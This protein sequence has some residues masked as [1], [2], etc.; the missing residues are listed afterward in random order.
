M[1]YF[2][3]VDNDAAEDQDGRKDKHETHF[4]QTQCKKTTRKKKLGGILYYSRQ[5][6]KM[7]YCRS[8]QKRDEVKKDGWEGE[9]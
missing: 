1:E 2:A 3:A 9:R 8:R 4:C 6:I 7:K 5:N